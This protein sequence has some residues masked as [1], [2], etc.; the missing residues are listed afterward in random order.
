MEIG[1]AALTLLGPLAL[2]GVRSLP[3]QFDLSVAHKTER[4]PFIVNSIFALFSC[5][6]LDVSECPLLS[7]VVAYPNQQKGDVASSKER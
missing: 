6:G 1:T 7:S 2:F 3:D 4:K 5:V